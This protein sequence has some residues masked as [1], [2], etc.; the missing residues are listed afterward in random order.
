MDA[1]FH[2]IDLFIMVIRIW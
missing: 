2:N 1:C